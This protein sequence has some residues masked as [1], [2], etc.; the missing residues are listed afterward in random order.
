M[1]SATFCFGQAKLKN[2]DTA[3]VPQT[4]QSHP[5]RVQNNPTAID[6]TNTEK[7]QQHRATASLRQRKTIQAAMAHHG[8]TADNVIPAAVG[9]WLA[10]LHLVSPELLLQLLSGSKKAM[11]A[12][13]QIVQ[14]HKAEFQRSTANVT[15]SVGVLYRGSIASK[16][17]YRSIYQAWTRSRSKGTGRRSSIQVMPNVAVDRML[18]YD[19]LQRYIKTIDIGVLQSLPHVAGEVDVNGLRRPLL[20]L[21]KIMAERVLSTPH[22]RKTL[23]WLGK[24]EGHFQFAI[25]GDGAPVNKA[26][27]ITIIMVSFLNSGSRVGSPN[28]NFLLAAGSGSE[29]HPV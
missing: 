16:I 10:F 29:L 11:A 27:D 22:L 20:D 2:N 19:S 9:L 8:A 24:E 7:S 5:R 14:R 13:R 4:K 28:E 23:N 12:I 1:L 21:L 25:G 17:K 26:D 15:R 3:A 6:P 18:S